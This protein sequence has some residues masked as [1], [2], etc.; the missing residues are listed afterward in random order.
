MPT[1]F[2]RALGNANVVFKHP[3]DVLEA[4]DLTRDQQV[5]ILQEWDYD[6][7]LMMVATEENMAGPNSG[8][9][10]E[11]RVAVRECLDRLGAT[12]AGSETK[13]GG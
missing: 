8:E 13:V 6:L 11:L 1:R 10:G 12:P 3:R 9:S 5:K 7:G 4:K 2:E